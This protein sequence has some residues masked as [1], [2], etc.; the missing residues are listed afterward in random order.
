[1][2]F[3]QMTQTET[4]IHW[5]HKQQHLEYARE[6]YQ[7]NYSTDLVIT[8]AFVFYQ[9]NFAASTYEE[10]REEFDQLMRTLEEVEPDF[11]RELVNWPDYF[12]T[13]DKMLN[14]IHLSI[15]N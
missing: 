4:I 12:V 10:H 13:L 1:M 11:K 8:A 6:D 5:L 2:N 14:E 15:S 3:E 7:R 9:N